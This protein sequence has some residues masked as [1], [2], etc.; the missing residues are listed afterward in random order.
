MNGEDLFERAKDGDVGCREQ[1][2]LGNRSLLFCFMKDFRV[3]ERDRDD[4]LQLGYI[5]FNQAI[6]SYQFGGLNTFLS[7]YRRS[8]LHHYYLYKL[9]MC[10]PSKISFEDYKEVLTNGFDY[11][12]FINLSYFDYD[13]RLTEVEDAIISK[14]VWEEV[15]RIVGEYWCKFLRLRFV[16]GKSHEEVAELFNLDEKN[17]LQ[18]R[19]KQ[20]YLLKKLRKSK[21]LRRI[22]K[23]CFEFKCNK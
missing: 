5:A 6:E 1:F 11:K 12:K 4:F 2:F 18:S 21:L 3:K 23:D 10:F 15:S 16:E 20:S 22:A 9:N 7:Y 19:S 8:V 14:I 13:E 17:K